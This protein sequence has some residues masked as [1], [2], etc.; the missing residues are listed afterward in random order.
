MSRF[1]DAELKERKREESAFI[2]T[3]LLAESAG[4]TEA[5]RVRHIYNEA[6]DDAA[7]F[8]RDMAPLNPMFAMC[9]KASENSIREF[10]PLLPDDAHSH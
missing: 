5:E 7:N 10:L 2:I 6:I 9:L 3:V 8:V 1:T 4:M